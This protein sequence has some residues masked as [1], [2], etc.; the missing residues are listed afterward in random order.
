MTW[1]RDQNCSIW[2]WRCPEP[3]DWKLLKNRSK[4]CAGHSA[5]VT[6]NLSACLST[7]T[8]DPSTPPVVRRRA[9]NSFRACDHIVVAAVGPDHAAGPALH[10]P[11]WDRARSLLRRARA[12]RLHRSERTMATRSCFRPKTIGIVFARSR[13]PIRS[14]RTSAPSP[15]VGRFAFECPAPDRAGCCQ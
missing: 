15:H 5:G 10:P 12:R 14:G 7:N 9:Q 2:C 11:R 4:E 8:P 3:A 13:R 1:D 6:K